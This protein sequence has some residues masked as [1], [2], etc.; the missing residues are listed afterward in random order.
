MKNVKS[1]VIYSYSV[2]TLLAMSAFGISVNHIHA[3]NVTNN[4]STAP[5]TQVSN[6]TTIQENTNKTAEVPSSES[7]QATSNGKSQDTSST[8]ETSAV[9]T[10]KQGENNQN[11]A[12]NQAEKVQ[13]L[14]DFTYSNNGKWSQQNDGIHSDATGQGDSFAYTDVKGDNFMYS[15]DVTFQKNEGAAAL[16]FR[17]NNNVDNKDG[18]AVNVD[19]GN[20][21]AK[22]WRWNNNKDYQLIDEKDVT[23]TDNNTYNLKVIAN[24]H[25][26]EYFV[27]D[28]LIASTGDYTLQKD[29]KG[30]PTITPEGYFGLL[31][32]NGDVVFKNIKY[33][34][35]DNKFS[36]LLSNIS[37]T[38]AKGKVEEKGQFASEQP[39][40]IQYVDNDADTVNLQAITKSDKA[41]VVAYDASGKEY[42]D[43]KNIPVHVGANYL[44]VISEITASD[45]TKVQA[46]YRVNVH[47]RQAQEI[48]YNELYR[49]Q[50]HFSVKDGW[51]ND[52]NGLVYFNNK[53]H[54][55]Y[56]FYDD[57]IWG[58]MHWA[59]ATSTD[60]IHWKNEPV[61]F[62]PDANGAMFSGSIVVDEGNTS[63][64]F[65]NAQGGLVA[66]ITA[67]GNGQRIEVAYSKDEGKTWNKLPMI[68]ADWQN[69]PL[70][71]PDFRDPKVFRWDNK[72]FMVL[73]G[74][75]LRIF[76]STNL[77]N[78]QVESEYPDIN[79]ECP[80]LY[81]V[82]AVDGQIKWVLSRGGRFYKV[83]DFHQINGKWTYTPDAD[84]KDQDGIMNFGKDSYAA[85]TYYQ[86]SF[87]T[88]ANPTLPD[89]IENNWMNTWD[90]CNLVG[91]TVGQEFNGTYNLNLKLGLVK[92]GNKYLLTQTP[93]DAYNSLRDTNKAIVYKNIDVTPN[94]DLFKDFKGD[95]YEIVSTFKPSKE[96]TKVGFNVRVGKGQA[97]KVVYDLTSNKIYIDRS[98]SGVQINNK[99][100]EINEQPVTRNADG[101]VT[102]HL[103]VDRAS[104]EVF[105]KDDTVTG[106]NQIFPSPQSLGLGVISEGGNSKADIALYPLKSIWTDKEKVTQPL[107]V[108][109]VSPKNLRLNVGDKTTLTAYVMP[110]N[111]QQDLIWK[112]SDPSLADVT[113]DGA[114]NSLILDTKNAGHLV[115]TVASKQDPTLTKD[116]NIDILAN[117]FK[118]NVKDLKPLSGNWYVDDVNL[119]DEN[120]S[121]N[122]YIMSSD[123]IPYPEYDMNVDVK[124]QKGLANIFFASANQDPNGAY[125][126]QLG[127]DATLRLYRFYGDT[128][129]QT[130]LPYALNDGKVHHV[131][132]HKTKNAV[133][134]SIDGNN[135]MDYT[136]DEADPGYNDAY[137]G[138]GLWDGSVDFQNFFVNDANKVTEQHES[139][140]DTPTAPSKTNQ[141]P[142][143]DSEVTPSK[144]TT[145]SSTVKDS[146]DTTK[147]VS[148]IPDSKTS[149]T[150]PVKTI[151][152]RSQS[153]NKISI[154][155]P[156][157]TKESKNNKY[158]Q[159]KKNELPQLSDTQKPGI[160]L[161]LI[162]AFS[163]SV[164]L[165][166]D[167]LRR[168]N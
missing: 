49:D 61:A 41:K 130:A 117:N 148:N 96:T 84:Y 154:Q 20:H 10:T 162:M 119:H 64:L 124:Y 68:V 55:F 158:S 44:T 48:Y 40:Y 155:L 122:D 22:F 32:W 102:L 72:W 109:Q 79:T 133:K 128:I 100:T 149:V 50:Y 19:G 30:Q 150:T 114:A 5:V 132:I 8:P 111:V 159:A 88:Q 98:Q 53:Y 17:G 14:T 34:T 95:T 57:T 116:Y 18:Y 36:P 42:T 137:V 153:G 24:G 94:N 167:K 165:F 80:D 69:D 135:V 31:N 1:T 81:P 67:D 144:T 21:K 58:P 136:F 63:G 45:G 90:Y 126:L 46:V 143:N 115:V 56:Q 62:Y 33:V 89:I 82:K 118:T 147:E 138:L 125:S 87:G 47:R 52:P 65:D 9:N 13:A 38:S 107:Q 164:L 168:R 2:T 43:L 161:G 106:A 37:V 166:W 76:S 146:S 139:N 28:T 78:W 35:L 163:S 12:Q 27:N 16:T 6:Q 59:H 11:I 151:K 75:P 91:N 83:G 97:T 141:T 71:S 101:S 121:S 54:M 142:E 26:M 123:K 160:L 145:E 140:K 51:G 15:A 73:A 99:F 110:G 131:S 127:G 108:V 92:D 74:G 120:V 77:I 134:V 3:D 112:V 29:D 86:H 103:Y 85:M 105:T 157:T 39:I 23:P 70:Q 4:T 113:E 129:T 60:L 152:L 93:V 25:W 156:S 7:S 66:I 104:V